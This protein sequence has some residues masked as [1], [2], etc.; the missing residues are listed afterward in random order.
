MTPGQIALRALIVG[1]IVSFAVITGFAYTTLFER[2]ILARL[3]GR[4]GPNRAGY[5]PLPRRGGKEIKLLGGIM[6]P[7]ADAVKLFFKEDP[8]PAMVDKVTYNLAPMLTVMPAILI[9]AVIPWAG[10]IKIFAAEFTPYFAIAPGLNVGVLFILAITSIS[11]YGI[12]LAGWASNSKYAVLGGIR[13][14]AQ[15][16]SYELALGLTVLVPIMIADSMDLGTIVQAQKGLLGWFVFRQPIAAFVFFVGIMAELQR[17]PFDLLEAEQELSAGF[18]VEYAGMRFGMFFMAEYMKMIAFSAIMATFF[19]GGY[20]GPFVE[21]VPALGFLYIT[22][23]IIFFLFLMV[24]IRAS[25]PRYRYDQLMSLGWKVLLPISVL[26]FIIV[27]V[28]IILKQEGVF[29]ALLPTVFG[30]V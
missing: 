10:E 4:I 11:V 3:Q 8:T 7:L 23:K 26:N 22:L 5:I 9:L 18:N 17:A 20:L 27:A 14:S 1:F 2:K 29:G 16:I 15:M 21:Q 25:L 13:A 19:F 6:Q 28:F 24:W 30:V 12:V